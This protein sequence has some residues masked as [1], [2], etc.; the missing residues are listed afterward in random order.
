MEQT[1]VLSAAYNLAIQDRLVEGFATS[2]VAH[3]ENDV[4]DALDGKR[5]QSAAHWDANVR[6]ECLPQYG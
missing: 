1:Q 5:I 3:P 2:E 4:V 6:P